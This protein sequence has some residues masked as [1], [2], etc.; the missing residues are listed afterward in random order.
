M[1]DY[2]IFSDLLLPIQVC[3]VPRLYFMPFAS[4]RK[5][6]QRNLYRTLALGTLE[7]T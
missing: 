5:L 4:M 1:N 7:V 2:A 3:S 6:D